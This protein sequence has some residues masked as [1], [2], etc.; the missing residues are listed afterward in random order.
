MT[1]AAEGR[2]PGHD[3]DRVPVELGCDA[4]F[5]R[6]RPEGEQADAGHQDHRGVRRTQGRR[7]RGPE[8]VVVCRV[9]LPVL[10]QALRGSLLQRVE[11]AGGRVPVDEERLEARP[12]EV[13]GTARAGCGEDRPVLR[14]DE[15][16][17]VG[18]VVERADRRTHRRHA[19]AQERQDRRRDLL[20]VLAHGVARAAERRNLRLVL[21]DERPEIVDDG[22]RVL[23]ALARRPAPREQAVVRQDDA[24]RL[25]VVRHRVLHHHRQ[26]EARPPPGE[27][28]ERPVEPAVE[29]GEPLPAV[30]AGGQRDRPIRVE[31]IDVV[32]R[33]ER[34]QRRIDGRL[35]PVVADAEAR[36]VRHHLVFVGFAP[37]GRLQLEQAREVQQ[38][39]AGAQDGAEVAA[40]ALHREHAHRLAGDRVRHLVLRARVA[41]P[42]VGDALVGPEQVGSVAEQ[43]ERAERRGFLFVP[44]VAEVIHVRFSGQ[45][46]ALQY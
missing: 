14:V 4:C 18:R 32:E 12:L 26:L 13:V 41:A 33:K 1:A 20:A 10:L 30:G 21:Q 28:D 46:P 29:L 24:L 40:A 5:L 22:Q 38:R 35:H 23:V 15:L 8:R 3:A 31:V 6:G 45:A 2:G 25:G 19:P 34:V 27:P 42:V 44:V 37:V 39:E 43:L 9:L 11:G 7:R 17:H 16:Q 36:V